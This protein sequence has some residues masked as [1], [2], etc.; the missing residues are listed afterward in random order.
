MYYIKSSDYSTLFS[1]SKCIIIDNDDN[2]IGSPH[3]CLK[4]PGLDS[5]NRNGQQSS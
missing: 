3:K 2:I 4:I 5:N 1:S